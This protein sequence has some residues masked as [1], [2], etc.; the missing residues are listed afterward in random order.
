MTNL[1]PR[2]FLL[3]HTPPPGVGLAPSLFYT[4]RN[5][6]VRRVTLSELSDNPHP[7]ATHSFSLLVDWFRREALPL[8]KC[9]I[10]LELARKL[11]VGRP[12]ADF[13]T[14]TPWDM[15]TM[16]QDFAP[17][18]FDRSLIR[19]SL[20]THISKPTQSEFGNL[21]FMKT[22]AA[23]LPS[24]WDTTRS[25]LELHQ[26][27]E[28]FE[29]IEVP[30]Y[31]IMLKAQY[32]GIVID[33]A[34][35]ETS[36]KAIENRYVFA[37]HELAINRNVDVSRAFNDV[38]YLNSLLQ[39][40][41][42]VDEV[43]AAPRE[44]IASRK[45][46]DQLCSLLNEVQTARTNKKI[47]LRTGVEDG[48]C[49]PLY[50]T[51]G[52]VTGRILTVDP[53]LQYL[54]KKYRAVI[55]RRPGMELLYL[56][57]AQFEP[58]I[59]ANISKDPTLSDLC[60]RDDLYGT[61]AASIFGEERHRDVIKTMF[62]SYSYGKAI[63]TLYEFLVACDM[64]A[65]EASI[66]IENCLMPLFS[67]VERWKRNVEETLIRDGRIST[68]FGNY[69]YRDVGGELTQ[70][71]RRWAVSQLIQGTGSLILKK[72]IIAVDKTL[73]EV[74]ILL[75]MHDALLVEVP[76]E[77]AKEFGAE[78]LDLFRE[79]FLQVCPLASPSIKLKQFAEELAN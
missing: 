50:D 25:D 35:R 29:T 13:D 6:P 61:L 42:R 32:E 44:I 14:E 8:P 43:F 27:I 18:S 4:S 60:R 51:L 33:N 23:K 73:P 10:D 79:S 41:V 70:R 57:Y 53:H 49:F 63:D 65:E 45:T 48:M 46:S 28:R 68:L 78:I 5:E 30:V 71:E 17:A 58:N 54:N 64:S 76:T 38:D 75:P 74:T 21:R 31:N 67:G 26:E 34:V 62:L 39:V 22:I 69:R 3:H 7:I 56:D 12:K 2:G 47:L 24:L 9:I 77:Y 55:T 11:I 40:P 20:T 72:A 1:A 37:H 16:L 66:R 19:A 36:L 52:T 59:M 15:A